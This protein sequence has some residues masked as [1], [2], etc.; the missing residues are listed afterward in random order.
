VTF[1]VV[2]P[3][4]NN[5]STKLRT[6]PEEGLMTTLEVVALALGILEGPDIEK[7]LLRPLKALIEQQMEWN[8]SLKDRVETG[9]VL[10]NRKKPWSF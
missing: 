8:P 4:T 7:A 2:L 5:S 10:P 3:T 6:E 1:K 9:H